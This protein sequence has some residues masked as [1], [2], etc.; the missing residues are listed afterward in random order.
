[1]IHYVVENNNGVN[2][3]NETY[4]L[5]TNSKKQI[6]SNVTIKERDRELTN[7]KQIVINIGRGGT[8][9]SAGSGSMGGEC[10][11]KGEDTIISFR[12]D[13]STKRLYSWYTKNNIPLKIIAYGGNINNKNNSQLY[14]T[15]DIVYM[16]QNNK[17]SIHRFY[18]KNNICAGSGGATINQLNN[19][20]KLTPNNTIEEFGNKFNKKE[21]FSIKGKKYYLYQTSNSQY[22]ITSNKNQIINYPSGGRG[23]SLKN[24][25][26]FD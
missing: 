5:N 21:L 11:T 12:L 7:N 9:G 17:G 2:G 25:I 19:E 16:S 18:K 1:M 8:G 23:G 6:I 15:G 26:S 14:Q 24:D 10:P 3:N 4:H 22:N 20:I 13:E